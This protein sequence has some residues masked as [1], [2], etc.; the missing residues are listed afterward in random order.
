MILVF[1]TLEY[2]DSESGGLGGSTNWETNKRMGRGWGIRLRE[3][4][5]NS[6]TGRNSLPSP[7]LRGATDVFNGLEADK[8]IE[9]DIRFASVYPIVIRL[10]RAM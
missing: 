10:K 7:L 3:A 8:R 6:L 9:T 5:G 4:V 2:W 1:W